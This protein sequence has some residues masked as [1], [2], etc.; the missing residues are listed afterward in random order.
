MAALP[1]VAWGLPMWEPT[2]LQNRHTVWRKVN[3]KT[4]RQ[5]LFFLNSFKLEGACKFE[6]TLKKNKKNKFKEIPKT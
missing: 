1:V 5:L 4:D 6:R 3:E 2:Y